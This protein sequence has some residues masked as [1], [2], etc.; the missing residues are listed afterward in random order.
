[1]ISAILALHRDESSQ[2]LEEH[3]LAGSL[4]M[5]CV[6]FLFNSLP[7]SGCT[8]FTAVVLAP[9]PSLQGVVDAIQKVGHERNALLHRLRLALMAGNN[10]EAL[11]FARQLCGLAVGHEESY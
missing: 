2:L 8:A 3:S 11:D 4:L 5:F 9:Q 1:M 6:I 10:D 7:S